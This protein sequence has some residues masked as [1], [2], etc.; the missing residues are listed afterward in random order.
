MWLVL[1][2]VTA[3]TAPALADQRSEAKEHVAFGINLAKNNLWREAASQW[4][5]AVKLDPSYGA[6]WNN[7]GIGLEQL[8]KFDEAREAYEKALRL[9]PDNTFIRN[10]YDQFREIY[11]RQNRRRE[12]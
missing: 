11:D 6:A 12:R 9:E 2:L 7:L 8:G 5:K 4:E 1:V 10:N 3:V